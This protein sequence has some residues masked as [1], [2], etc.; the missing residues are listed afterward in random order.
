MNN[1]AS[2]I[3]EKIQGLL[4]NRGDEINAWFAAASKNTP[5][6]VYNSVDLRNS[7]FKLAPVDTNL[8]PAGFNNLNEK[9]RIRAAMVVKEFFTKY[10]EYDFTANLEEDLDR[11]AEGK[12]QWKELLKQ[13]WDGFSAKVSEMGSIKITD[14]IE[15][16]EKIM[17]NHLFP[18]I[19]DS[20]ADPRK[21]PAC[22]DGRL[23][24]RLGKFGAF[25]ACGNY[26]EC[27][28]KKSIES[29]DGGSIDE[30]N[31]DS[32]I[33]E[34]ENKLL[35]EVNQKEVFLKKGPYG[36]YVELPDEIINGKPKRVS[37]PPFVKLE[38]VT[39]KKAE[40][41]LSL[42]IKLGVNAESQEI[43]IGIGKFGPYIK[44]GNKFTSIPKSEDP[45]SLNLSR[46][47]EIIDEAVKMKEKKK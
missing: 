8:F 14:V 26:P 4:A 11:V 16:L 17:E 41:L 45:F 46:A 43:S 21:C 12:M 10:V 20:D 7:G 9:E 44:C 6:F 3:I 34:N 1:T 42:P 31:S 29:G 28:Y 30:E 37:I 13:F 40:E 2:P 36:Y 35:G 5:P 19:K 32:P 24:L 27:N 38:D 15:S 47:L 39:L 25:I 18:K 22:T 33:K 23:G